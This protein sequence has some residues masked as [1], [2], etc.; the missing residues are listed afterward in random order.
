MRKK[1]C[2][3]LFPSYEYILFRKS[4]THRFVV[5]SGRKL[6]EFGGGARMSERDLR[7]ELTSCVN[8][9]KKKRK[10]IK[11]NLIDYSLLQM[12]DHRRWGSPS[13]SENVLSA[14]VSNLRNFVRH[15]ASLKIHFCVFE[16]DVWK[17]NTFLLFSDSKIVHLEHFKKHSFNRII[18]VLIR[19]KKKKKFSSSM[20]TSN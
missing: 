18:L 3:V 13:V 8:F 5:N 14:Y 17:Y 11:M 15:C 16:A 4:S 6:S 20:Q 9:V 1:L 2:Q 7:I 19:L 12:I 10:D